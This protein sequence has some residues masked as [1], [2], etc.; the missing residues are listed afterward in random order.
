MA[1][2][3]RTTEQDFTHTSYR[4]FHIRKPPTMG[5]N[6]K[7][8]GDKGGAKGK[9]AEGK[10]SGGKTKGA[11]SI[12]VRH[13]LVCPAEVAVKQPLDL[14]LCLPMVFNFIY[15]FIVIVLNRKMTSPLI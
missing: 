5:K 11:M 9:G 13:I 15:A 7:K 10:E 12:N 1:G 6:D 14:C 2:L 3:I 8:S 4:R